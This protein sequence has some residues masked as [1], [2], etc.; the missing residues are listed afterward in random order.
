MLIIIFNFLAAINYGIFRTKSFNETSPMY[1]MFYDMGAYGTQ[2]S[3]VSYQLVKSKDR[4]APELQPQLT[5][6]GVGF[7]H[8]CYIIVHLII[9]FY[10]IMIYCNLLL[11]MNVI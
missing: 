2:A 7:V 8:T 11:A 6:L 5:V 9:Y 10:L 4:I 3:V 1:M